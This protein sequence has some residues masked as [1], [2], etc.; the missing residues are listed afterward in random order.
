MAKSTEHNDSEKKSG[1]QKKRGAE[2]KGPIGRSVD[3]VNEAI[4]EL[5]KVH[6]PTRQETIQ[7]T[8]GVLLMVFFFGLFL[9]LGDLLVGKIMQAVLT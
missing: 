4:D 1:S 9:G 6:T 7:G 8:I 3:F 5:K 2:E